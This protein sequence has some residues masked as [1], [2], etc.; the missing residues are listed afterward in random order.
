MMKAQMLGRARLRFQSAKTAITMDGNSLVS[1]E[2]A[3]SGQT[4]PVQLSAASPISAGLS[5]LNIG[6]N[7]ART[8]QMNG[9]D[10]GSVTDV[11]A[12]WQAGKTNVLILWEGTNS[13]FG[14]GRTAAEAYSDMVSYITNRLA[15]HPWRIILLTTIPRHEDSAAA[16]SII[17]AQNQKLVDYNNLILA[18]Y[19]S[20]GVESVVDVRPPGGP[21]NFTGYSLANDFRAASVQPYWYTG[22]GNRQIHLNNAGYGL[23]A[24]YIAAALRRLPARAP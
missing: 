14:G 13:M 6:V 11:Q 18:N 2:T 9:L 3:T 23:I 15:E 7:G 17:D 22:D 1:A 5:V 12:A 16:Q 10:G 4:V 19:K 8:R 20:I 21:F 24:S